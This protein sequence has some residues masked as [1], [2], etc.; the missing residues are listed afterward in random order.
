[1][2]KLVLL[3]IFIFNFSFAQNNSDKEQIQ[4]VMKDFLNC[5]KTKDSVKFYSLFY[6]EPVVWVGTIKNKSYQK[7][8]L[9]N[10]KEKQVFSDS[11]KEFMKMVGKSSDMEEKYDN[12]EIIEDGNIASVNFDYS[13]WFKGKMLNWGKE[14]WT[15]VKSDGKWKI[16]SVSFSME[17]TEYFQQ[18]SLKERLKHK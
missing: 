2:K 13:F 17:M 5:I 7:I 10:P 12:V 4:H 8:L 3:L 1:M 15:L 9:K 18:P 6:E 11:Y 16:T 14:I